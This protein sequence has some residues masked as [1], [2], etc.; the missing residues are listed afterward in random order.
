M[1]IYAIVSTP[2][3]AEAL[4]KGRIDYPQ[5]QC[6]RSVRYSL[7][8]QKVLIEGLFSDEEITWFQQYSEFI[9]CA[10]EVIDYI[11]Q[12]RAEWEAEGTMVI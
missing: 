1:H 7:D 9:G 12:H 8:S 5:P 2:N 4:T 10:P 11:A 3:I 6:N